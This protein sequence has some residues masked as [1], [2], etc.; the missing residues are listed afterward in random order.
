MPTRAAVTHP[1]DTGQLRSHL[2]N[3]TGKKRTNRES[4]TRLNSLRNADE[5]EL[6]ND[7]RRSKDR[8]IKRSSEKE[9]RVD[10]MALIADEG[11]DKLRKAWGSCK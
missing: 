10:A 5:T 4:Q 3:C 1:K 7:L 9:R 2:E 11:R 6:A 8:E